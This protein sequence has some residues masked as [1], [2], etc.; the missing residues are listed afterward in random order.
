MTRAVA[1]ALGVLAWVGVG[2]VAVAV[3]NAWRDDNQVLA[4]VPILIAVVLAWGIGEVV[5]A[6]VFGE[7]ES[8][9]K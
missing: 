9:V 1:L 7:H 2:A 4:F 5:T 8:E 3:V 6:N